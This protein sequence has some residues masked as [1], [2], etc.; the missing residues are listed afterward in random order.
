[1]RVKKV[2]LLV[3]V[4]LGVAGA[5]ADATGA[6]YPGY[7]GPPPRYGDTFDLSVVAGKVQAHAPG[8]SRF[9][10]VT[11]PETLPVGTIL[12]TNRG[13]ARLTFA[14]TRDGSQRQTA[15]FYSGTFRVLQA[16]AGPPIT[17]LKLENGTV[18]PGRAGASGGARSQNRGLW[19]DG[20]GNFRT[21]GKY[22][23]A[24]VR[25]TI[26]WAQDT[27]GGTLFRVKRGVVTIRVFSS[28]RTLEL[29]AGQRY[30]APD[31]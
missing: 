24:T 5:V 26:W 27:C 10:P 23:S 12:D 29:H 1:V 21:V 31:G 11:R 2:T 18:C 20:K 8:Q 30:L 14:K 16:P 22:G 15:E 4:T 13:R 25:G 28:G 6:A 7:P 17:V 3:L 9:A 19:G